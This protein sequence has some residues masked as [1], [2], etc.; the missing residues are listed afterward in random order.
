MITTRNSPRRSAKRRIKTAALL[1]SGRRSHAENGGGLYALNRATAAFTDQTATL[2]SRNANTHHGGGAERSHAACIEVLCFLDTL[3][4]LGYVVLLETI[5]GIGDCLLVYKLNFTHGRESSITSHASATRVP[6]VVDPR[7]GRSCQGLKC[8]V[9]CYSTV[10]E[11]LYCPARCA[12]VR[13]IQYSSI[14]Q[15]LALIS[16]QARQQSVQ[17]IFTRVLLSECTHARVL[18]SRGLKRVSLPPTTTVLFVFQ[19][20]LRAPDHERAFDASRWCDRC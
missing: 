11:Y 9:E 14:N 17:S 4:D 18:R 13:S 2:N 3:S 8:G 1:L 19:Q 15:R 5:I 6:Q 16:A 10:L 20:K 12:S 7:P